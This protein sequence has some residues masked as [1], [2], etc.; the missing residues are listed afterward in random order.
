MRV[1]IG[2]T[3]YDAQDQPLCIEVTEEEQ[4]Q[5]GALKREE[6]SLGRYAVFPINKEFSEAVMFN[7][8]RE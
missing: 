3:W 5:I 6:E 2:D 7:W 4:R 8:M 1:K